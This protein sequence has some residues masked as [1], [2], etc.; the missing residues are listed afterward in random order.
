MTETQSRTSQYNAKKFCHMRNMFVYKQ[1]KY[2]CGG[3][4]SGGRPKASGL[5]CVVALICEMLPTAS[6]L[7][8]DLAKLC[9]KHGWLR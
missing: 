3:L 5:H 2:V 1:V 8:N 6:H 7:R 4:V 9:F